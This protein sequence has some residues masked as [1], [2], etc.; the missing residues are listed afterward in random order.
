MPGL[1]FANPPPY[2]SKYFKQG[3]PSFSSFILKA[4]RC[5]II[6]GFAACASAFTFTT[7]P[8][9]RRVALHS[10]EDDSCDVFTTVEAKNSCLKQ[11]V[12]D[13]R[14]LVSN[15]RALAMSWESMGNMLQKCA[16]G[17]GSRR[18]LKK[19][20]SD[21][22]D[23]PRVSPPLDVSLGSPAA[24]LDS[25]LDTDTV[26]DLLESITGELDGVGTSISRTLEEELEQA[27]SREQVET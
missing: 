20:D 1:C 23:A 12:Q 2:G 6:L 26:D 5:A 19:P 24:V 22:H 14:R 17:Y 10:L 7:L 3:R 27:M 15:G 9:R 18:P 13:A 16:D 8:Q 4:M 11:H 25:S 21:S